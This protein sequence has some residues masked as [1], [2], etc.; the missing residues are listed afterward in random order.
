[1]FT[2]DE[3]KG[4]TVSSD[5]V[6]DDKGVIICRKSKQG[7]GGILIATNYPGVHL[8]L[9]KTMQSTTRVYA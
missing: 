6:A 7:P 8:F 4:S 9:T 3:S 1:L 5:N 2:V